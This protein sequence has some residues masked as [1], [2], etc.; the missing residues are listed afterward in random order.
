MRPCLLLAV[1]IALSSLP[2]AGQLFGVR[3]GCEPY[4]AGLHFLDPGT[5]S[6]TVVG[7][8][9]YFQPTELE[10]LDGGLVMT[11]GRFGPST[12]VFVDPV[13]GIGTHAVPLT[14][15][16]VQGLVAASG[17]LY[18]TRK[19]SGG[20]TDLVTIDTVT[21]IVTTVGSTGI[22]APIAGMVL[23]P[24]AGNFL[25]VTSGFS[26]SQ[27]LSIDPVTGTATPILTITP[28]PM[29]FASLELIGNTLIGG[30]Y[31]GGLHSIDPAT[32]V[33]TAIG[34]PP[35]YSGLAYIP[36]TGALPGTDEGLE[37]WSSLDGGPNT[38]VA[39]GTDVRPVTPGS[40]VQLVHLSRG[41]T[42]DGIGVLIVLGS[43]ATTGTTV[44]SPFPG[45]WL[46]GATLFVFTATIGGIP[47]TLGPAGFSYAFPYPGGL[48]GSSMLIQGVVAT[49]TAANNIFA[50]TNALELVLL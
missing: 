21:G 6:S 41:G 2:A 25:G 37:T 40:H 48:G 23:D 46:D 34:V 1:V 35:K 3:P 24:A 10:V 13:T 9:G 38:A 43:V 8:I 45:L 36:T 30:A 31:S 26:A 19:V 33:A 49:G 5:G 17:V 32:G 28:S 47:V 42:F 7:T 22:N 4:N 50:S 44:P 39:T 20:P 15:G 29:S 11:T 12:L 16:S 14:G 18:G 27:L